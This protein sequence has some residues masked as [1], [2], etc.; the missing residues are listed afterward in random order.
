MPEIGYLLCE[1]LGGF[2]DKTK[3]RISDFERGDFEG[4]FDNSLV[5]EN[6]IKVLVRENRGIFL[7]VSLLNGSVSGERHFS[8]HSGDVSYGR[9][10]GIIA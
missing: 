2:G 6:R 9:N 10:S 3:L 7:E 1:V 8:V 5:Y 4:L